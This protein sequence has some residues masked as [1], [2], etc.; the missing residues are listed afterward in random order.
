VPGA[1]PPVRAAAMRFRRLAFLAGS[2]ALLAGTVSPA[3]RAD[4]IGTAKQRAAALHR[5]LSSLQDDAARA[6]GEFEAVN[7]D[8]EQAVSDAMTAREELEEAEAASGDAQVTASNRVRALYMSGGRV[9]LYAAVLQSKDPHDA[10]AQVANISAMVDVDESAVDTATHQQRRA[11]QAF[12]ALE[13]A[14]SSKVELEKQAQEQARKIELL[15]S[16]QQKL[17]ASADATVQGLLEQQRRKLAAARQAALLAEAARLAGLGAGPS[18]GDFAAPYRPAGGHYSCPVGPN[19]NFI[20]SWHA[21]RSGGRQHQGTDVFAPEGSPAYAVTDG[22]IDKWGNGGLGG[23]TLWLRA[24]NG[25]R[26]YYAHNA[27]NLATVGTAVKAGD[28]IALVGKTG[29]ARTTPPHV[30]FEAHPG[31]GGAANPY[32]FL[33][34]ICGKL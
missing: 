19:N 32:P 14:T 24:A 8:L 22:V 27:A 4:E 29:N 1:R 20:D 17:V 15:L 3:A 7:G 28:V 23:I 21:P 33:A 5:Q 25:D 31:G 12:A 13:K 30:H 26:Y 34:A 9:A 18:A 11:Q 2:V 16:R 6:V 10:L